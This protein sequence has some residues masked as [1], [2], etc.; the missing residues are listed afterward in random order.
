MKTDATKTLLILI[1]LLP[2]MSLSVLADEIS[3]SSDCT[4][5]NCGTT[6][7][8]NDTVTGNGD[9]TTTATAIYLNGSSS[10]TLDL[11]GDITTTNVGAH[12]IRIRDSDSNTITM[13]GDITTE[14]NGIILSDGSESN[15][16]NMTG[17]FTTT[18]TAIYLIGS[19]S[20]TLDLTGDITTTDVG[21]HGIRIRDSDSNTITMKGDITTNEAIG[22]NLSDG[23]ESNTINMT[24]DITTTGDGT[25]GHIT[26]I[27]NVDLN[28]LTL[29]GNFTTTGDT[30]RV[31]Y[32]GPDSNNNTTTVVG[33]IS[34]TGQNADAVYLRTGSNNNTINIT[35]NITT[36][37]DE[38]RGIR[39]V[40]NSDSNTLNLTGDI[41]TTG[42]S[43]HG[44]QLNNSDSNT[45]TING[46]ISATG[47]SAY[48]IYADSSS[49]NNIINLTLNRG[50]KLVGEIYNDGS[51]NTLNIT[52]N[53]GRTASYIYTS[54]GSTDL[55]WNITDS[56]K[57]VINGSA[58]SRGIADIDD[59]GNK[60]YQ[61][62]NPIS[63]A[64]SSQ[65]KRM[66]MGDARND[67]WIDG[68][69]SDSDR[70]TL[71]KELNHKTRGLTFGFNVSSDGQLPLDL[72][73]NIENSD[74][75]YG[76]SDQ[77][78]DTNSVMAGLL[79][80][81]LIQAF[82]GSLALK[83][84]TGAADN[85][86]YIKVLCNPLS[87]GQE[88]VTEDYNSYYGM[89][90]G[91]WLQPIYQGE[92]IHHD[93]YLGLDVMHEKINSRTASSYFYMSDRD[94]TQLN[95]SI[96]YGFSFNSSD[97]KL[98]IRAKA[99]IEQTDM[100]DGEYQYY[101]VDGTA[102]RFK[103]DKRNTY[104]TASLG[105]DYKFTDN[106]K[107]YFNMQKFNS[108]DDIDGTSGYLGFIYNF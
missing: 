46:G 28:T 23:S 82:N 8:G 70:T 49:D 5:T 104:M 72:I 39:L 64:T 105:A 27:N 13:K 93:V 79:Y 100:L 21:A 26:W 36:T 17:D 90:G 55:I 11:T 1:I 76:L 101:K 97:K 67:I 62:F 94:I 91:E 73:V 41:I 51:G 6:I 106:A 103:G 10:N 29:E 56:S 102:T 60:L 42:S 34:T 65:H 75:S 83:F 85:K 74:T 57:P 50:D 31:L 12:G 68:Y 35:G 48:A 54:S 19:S 14:A 25:A 37:G 78:I 95:S 47:S 107:A 81:E 77:S 15:T 87:S 71:Y 4:S 88:T 22:I 16:I 98:L 69:Y 9:I 86:S 38:S 92:N 45:V 40:S 43:S 89:V 52:L 18:A 84:L 2:L 30:A 80:P 99:S 20:N 61:R 59:A 96:N 32:L 63:R 33:N 7:D 44:L 58:K 3:W 53:S 108:S 66:A 24:G